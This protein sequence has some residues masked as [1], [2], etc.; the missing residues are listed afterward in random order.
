LPISGVIDGPVACEPARQRCACSIRLQCDRNYPAALKTDPNVSA[1]IAMLQPKRSAG[2]HTLPP[3]FCTCKDVGSGLA[4]LSR[5]HYQPFQQH[6]HQAEHDAS[7][8]GGSEAQNVK[9]R[10][11]D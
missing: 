11:E 6:I 5:W 1:C 10:N 3:L 8:E 4:S 7:P 9:S 2:F